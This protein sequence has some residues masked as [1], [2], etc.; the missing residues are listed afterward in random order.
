MYHIIPHFLSCKNYAMNTKSLIWFC[1]LERCLVCCYLAIEKG[2]KVK[3][4]QWNSFCPRVSQVVKSLARQNIV[5]VI[6]P[7]NSMITS[8]TQDSYL[9]S[10]KKL[11]LLNL[12]SDREIQ[13][14]ICCFFINIILLT[15]IR[16]WWQG[17]TLGACS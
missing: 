8:L 10:Q 11:Y 15:A 6:I 4:T 7:K 17:P 16:I 14:N 3:C 1:L 9:D 5:M 2:F 12:L 13:A